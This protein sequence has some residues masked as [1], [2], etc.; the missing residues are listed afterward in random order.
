MKIKIGDFMKSVLKN[1]LLVCFSL[2]LMSAKVFAADATLDVTDSGKVKVP[3]GKYITGG[4]IGSAVGLGIGH[5]IQDRY[6]DKGLIFTA[7]E[8]AGLTAVLLGASQCK[9]ETDSLGVKKTNCDSGM[10]TMLVGY[11]V[12]L[13]FHIWEVVDIWTGATPVDTTEPQGL[14]V[15]P[16]SG[17]TK[18]G[19]IYNF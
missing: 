2:T 15:I 11:G 6:H 12:F 19:Y 5:A 16:D 3:T 9:T 4:I 1:I 13:G 18:I 10:S 7:T 8:A 17:T 14:F